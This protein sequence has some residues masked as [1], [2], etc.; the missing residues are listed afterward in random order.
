MSETRFKKYGRLYFLFVLDYAERVRRERGIGKPTL[1]V[2]S[3]AT[4]QV[5]SL[6]ENKRIRFIAVSSPIF[7]R[8]HGLNSTISVV[9]CTRVRQLRGV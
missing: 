4:Y 6:P 7:R 2:S 5:T 9:C 8:Y 3:Y 1:V